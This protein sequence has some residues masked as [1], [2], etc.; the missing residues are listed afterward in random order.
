MPTKPIPPGM[1]INRP[2]PTG[3]ALGEQL[4]RFTEME[5]TAH[6]QRFPDDPEMCASC[7]FRPGTVPNGCLTTV[8]DALKSVVE[9]S[10]FV[11]HSPERLIAGKPGLPCQGWAILVC[12]SS[13]GGPIAMPWP[14]STESAPDA[15]VLDDRLTVEAAY[16]AREA[17]IEWLRET[18]RRSIDPAAWIGITRSPSGF[19]ERL[20]ID[21]LTSAQVRTVLARLAGE[22]A[23]HALEST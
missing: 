12:A 10:S 4:A 9:M 15:R 11:C 19:G 3:R 1:A 21:G 20:V 22:E 6:Y 2:C 23:D 14:F 16:Y 8:T 18:A 5:S 13:G 17:E 7:A